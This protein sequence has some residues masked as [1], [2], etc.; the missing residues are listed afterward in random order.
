MAQTLNPVPIVGEAIPYTPTIEVF[1]RNTFLDFVQQDVL[2][3]FVPEGGMDWAEAESTTAYIH[4][5][6]ETENYP[7]IFRF[8]SEMVGLN[9]G[10]EIVSKRVF[11]RLATVRFKR[12]PKAG[13]KLYARGKWYFV[14]NPEKNSSGITDLK[15]RER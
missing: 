3:V 7:M 10:S 8:R 12:T 14:E 11:A 9:A 4:V 13:D 2:N 5:T 1:K 15:L 6:G